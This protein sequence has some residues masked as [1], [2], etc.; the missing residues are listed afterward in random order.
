MDGLTFQPNPILRRWLG[1]DAPPG[2]AHSAVE[3]L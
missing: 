1:E 3:F 2:L